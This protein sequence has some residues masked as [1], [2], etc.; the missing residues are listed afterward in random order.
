[1]MDHEKES[2][3]GMLAEIARI[4]VQNAELS[5]QISTWSRDEEPLNAKGLRDLC[6]KQM[7][8]S[9]LNLNRVNEEILRLL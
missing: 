8:A 5:I 3:L 2:R 9:I 6:I 1:M 4:Q 7:E